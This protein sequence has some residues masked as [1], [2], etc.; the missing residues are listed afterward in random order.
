MNSKNEALENI[1]ETFICDGDHIGAVCSEH[2][3]TFYKLK[4]LA[5]APTKKICVIKNW[6]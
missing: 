6:C 5:I 1:I 4:Y 3:I 2:D